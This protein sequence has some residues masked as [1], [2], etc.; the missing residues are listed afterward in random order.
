MIL[1]LCLVAA[2]AFSVSDASARERFF[3]RKQ[4]CPQQTIVCPLAP[5]P[6]VSVE[7]LA[8]EKTFKINFERAEWS[9]VF[10]W[11][12]KETGLIHLDN[13]VIPGTLTLKSDEQ[14]TLPQLIDLLNEVLAQKEWIIIRREHSFLLHPADEK[15]PPEILSQILPEELPKRGRSEFV[16]VVIRLHEGIVASEVA[17]QARKLLS[18]FGDATAFGTNQLIVRDK[19][20]NVR[21]MLVFLQYKDAGRPT[22]V[23]L[24]KNYSVPEAETSAKKIHAS[25]EFNGHNVKTLI[26]GNSKVLIYATPNDHLAIDI[27]LNGVKPTPVPCPMVIEC[28]RPT[29][30]AHCQPLRNLLRRGR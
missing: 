26:V 23:P 9:A 24:W 28:P 11:F 15:V 7:P 19:A 17:Q 1:R 6:V 21:N 10:K 18:V 30:P 16:Q 27:F 4:P 14:Y 20:K 8:I 12:S 29:P 22:V 2:L 13:G 5:T 25:P 3:F